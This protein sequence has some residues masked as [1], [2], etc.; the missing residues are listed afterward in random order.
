VDSLPLDILL[1]LLSPAVIMTSAAEP[2]PAYLAA[3]DKGPGI[4]ATICVV[5]V[6]ET[7]FCAA[8]IYTRGRILGRLQLDDYLVMLS[9]VSF[10][11]R[12]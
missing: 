7:L 5:T 10:T 12:L 4:I 6:L 8:R 11:F 3:E 2:L 1:L 9:V